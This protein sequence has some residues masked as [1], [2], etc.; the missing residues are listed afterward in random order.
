MVIGSPF[1]SLASAS[2]IITF[3]AV[4]VAVPALVA[5][6]LTE[7]LDNPLIYP[8]LSAVV[9]SLNLTVTVASI[10]KAPAGIFKVT[11][12]FSPTLKFPEQL[13]VA[14]PTAFTTEVELKIPIIIIKTIKND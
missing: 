10:A 11:V 12:N 6:K 9:P 1:V 3:V 4:I 8:I 5:V 2:E 13:K 7:L 14:L